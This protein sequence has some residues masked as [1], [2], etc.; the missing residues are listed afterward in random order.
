MNAE[1]FKVLITTI[2]GAV[3]SMTL[4][5]GVGMTVMTIVLAAAMAAVF[6]AWG[7]RIDTANE[8]A[9]EAK[10]AAVDLT[11]AVAG[12]ATHCRELR[13]ECREDLL[14]RFV[15]REGVR[16]M[17]DN[18]KVT[19]GQ[20]LEQLKE[21]IADNKGTLV[22]KFDELTG[23]LENFEKDVWNALH[24]HRHAEKDGAVIRSKGNPK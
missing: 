2:T 22:S 11:A 19:L 23:H 6:Q 8:T 5:G 12:S 21:L 10:A 3:K 15:P 4:V 1:Q 16:A 9:A 18:V 7:K 17:D 24:G 20:Q 14:D 13:A